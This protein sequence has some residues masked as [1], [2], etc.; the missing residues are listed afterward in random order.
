MNQHH[1]AVIMAGGSGTRVWPL[2][3][4]NRPKQFQTLFGGES[5]LQRIYGLL[6][7]VFPASHILVQTDQ[8]FLSLAREQLP[9][10]APENILCEP[11]ARDTAPA[12]GFA[13]AT[14]LQRDPEARL[15]VFCSDHLIRDRV[16]FATAVRA[17]YAALE[18]HSDTMVMIGVRPHS[19][20]TG[21]GYIRMG[22]GIGWYE[23]EPVFQAQRFIEKPD[24]E[25][26]QE[27]VEAGGWLWNTGN[28]VC[29]AEY[30]LELT[31]SLDPGMGE[32]LRTIGALLDDP[33]AA[34]RRA[35][36][37]RTLPKVSFELL[38][39]ERFRNLLVVPVEM[40]WSD[41][42]DWGALL[43]ALRA[44][45]E[46]E[47]A[48][49]WHASVRCEGCSVYNG[50]GR[51]IATLGLKDIL[52]IDAGDALL[53]VDKNNTQDLKELIRVLEQQNQH[54]YL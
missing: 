15:G 7:E 21:M 49:D 9:E 51:L 46:P 30:L 1:Y 10:L 17:A 19:P 18:E 25:T 24:L 42:G 28:K 37:Y 14:L 34:E 6:R 54:A 5:M 8:R 41:V 52:I 16:P 47:A 44:A 45:N 38:V 48:P 40:G 35:E 31:A 11:E 29:R 32:T 13:A 43:E 4:R 20:H 2:S 23:R 27:L 39:T 3:R 53:V 33:A 36:L 12:F 26:A 22:A 50:S